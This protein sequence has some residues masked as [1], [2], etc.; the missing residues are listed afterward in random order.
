MK[1]QTVKRRI[2]ISN[3]MMV[4]VVLLLTILINVCIV[5]ICWEAMEHEWQFSMESMVDSGSVEDLLE[6]WT[7]HQQSFYVLILIDALICIVVLILI[8]GCCGIPLRS[9]RNCY[10]LLYPLC[11]DFL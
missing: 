5:K 1:K 4:G 10:F 9:I 8:S 3:A 7:V 11:R 6:E 2:F